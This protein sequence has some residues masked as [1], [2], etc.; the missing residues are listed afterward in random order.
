MDTAILPH[1][2]TNPTVAS[3]DVCA[4]TAA[5]FFEHSVDLFIV[6]D[7]EGHILQLNRAWTA[8]LGWSASELH[9][10]TI[11]ELA[12]PNDLADVRECGEKLRRDGHA[13]HIFR[14]PC[15]SNNWRWMQGSTTLTPNGELIGVFRDITED[16][17][18]KAELQQLRSV[19]TLLAE[20]AGVASWTF[21]P[22]A[23]KLMWSRELE[24]ILGHTSAGRESLD[25]FR[26]LVHPDDQDLFMA[27]MR[28]AVQDGGS[29]AFEHRLLG[30]VDN[31]VTFRVTYR[32]E[33][34]A[35]QRHTIYGLC[36][37]IT[38]IAEARDAALMSERQVGQL[39]EGAPFAAAMYDGELRHIVVSPRWPTVFGH[40]REAYLGQTIAAVCPQ[41]PKRFLNAQ[42]RA[43]AG[44]VVT[45]REDRFEDADGQARW[46]R[47]EVRPWRD[48]SGAV[49]GVVA[50]VDDVT[51]LVTARR[52]ANANARRLKL[53]LRS[54]GAG[55]FE[56]DYDAETCWY[57]PEFVSVVGRR[58]SFNDVRNEWWTNLH[59]DDVE[60]VRTGVAAWD[61]KQPAPLEV[62]LLHPDGTWRWTRFYYELKREPGSRRVNRT[63]GMIIDIDERKRG[64]I[65]L[66]EAERQASAATEAKSRFLA[67]MSHE[68]RT[69][70]NG[71]M[72]VM[73]LLRK[74][75]MSPNALGLLEE[76][77]NCGRMLAEILDDVIDFS[78]IEAG[79]LELTPESLDPA[80][81]LDGV[82]RL[83]RPQ[84]EAKG[85]VL[86]TIAPELQAWA[87]ADPVRLR[88][89]L[90]NLLGNAVK[91]TTDGFVEVRLS[92]RGEGAD[93]RLRFEIQDT[94]I[95]IPEAAQAALFE[96][97][98]QADASSARRFGGSGLGL[99][100]SRR[101]AEMMGGS[102]G[103]ISQPGAGSTFFLE[104]SAPAASA[105]VEEDEDVE[106]LSALRVLVV[107]DNATNRMIVA[108]VLE[109]SGLSVE[110][111][112]DGEAAVAA[113]IRGGFDLILMDVQM[114]GMDGLEATKHIRALGSPQAKAPI[115]AL[116]ANVMAHQKAAYHAIGMN[117]VVA[118]P[119]SA[120]VLLAE[121]AKATR[122]AND[123]RAV[124]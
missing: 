12:H 97:F 67:N 27:R 109:A 16:Q 74:E 62:R 20:S 44:E 58:L 84:A 1:G 52:D 41:M 83:L 86:R 90:F 47:W 56:I 8:L 113:A 103:F 116:T 60:R 42:R 102:V 25:G 45:R 122:A 96:R 39:V 81:L 17:A 46:V 31:W 37:N 101:L 76:A 50:Y 124:A 21:D 114:P 100:I 121:I 7:Y 11:P 9:G 34:H 53:A 72:G 77:L 51:A 118:K 93:Q 108:R 2:P 61:A 94:G 40:E 48:G 36:Q 95:G 117:G 68:I 19:R 4:E 18:Y 87:V 26:E 71:V 63:V 78:K 110:T 64:E 106:G 5:W 57:S 104:I 105:P 107:D 119:I 32:T 23:D 13:R 99:V 3:P 69:P 38:E 80:A 65:A 91:F 88:Q 70:M 75:P 111:A 85:L 29:G 55:V 98:H 15:K 6:A 115:L 33:P 92:Q 59:P 43:L 28:D 123:D 73:Q 112:D 22:E 24:A 120:P 54:A 82:A 66:A 89:C 14:L 30:P 49:A 10:R 35:N 79:R